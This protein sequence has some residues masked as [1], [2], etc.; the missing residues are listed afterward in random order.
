[1]DQ[2]DVN[3]ALSDVHGGTAVA[4]YLL[5][6]GYMSVER[7]NDYAW[8][9]QY[10]TYLVNRHTT[11]A[12]SN[13]VDQ[14]AG[15][16]VSFIDG[17][18]VFLVTKRARHDNDDDDAQSCSTCSCPCYDVIPYQNC[19][20][21]FQQQNDDATSPCSVSLVDAS[22]ILYVNPNSVPSST[23]ACFSYTC[24]VMTDAWRCELT[25][26]CEWSAG[27][28]V[29]RREE[30]PTEKT[31]S[32]M[33]DQPLHVYSFDSKYCTLYQRISHEY[34][35][36]V[37]APVSVLTFCVPGTSKTNTAAIVAPIVVIVL[38]AI[39][40]LCAFLYWRRRG[41][42]LRRTVDE[43]PYDDYDVLDHN[44]RQS[45]LLK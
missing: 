24:D 19:E 29:I 13:V 26:T 36:L 12:T 27:E 30:P 45:N 22:Q 5:T 11:T 35:F 34:V 20:N 15:I 43:D 14:D 44:Q 7:C 32:S 9:R 2:P 28:C 16:T 37:H 4:Q 8:K 21:R 42:P 31:K 3:V 1:M 23:P 33:P 41:F 18:N 17:S 39:A 6:A 25:S 10:H 38:I 40:A